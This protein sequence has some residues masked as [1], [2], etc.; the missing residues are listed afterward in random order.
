[1]EKPHVFLDY[2]GLIMDYQFTPETLQRAHDIALRLI[3]SHK[4]IHISPELL[5]ESHNLAIAEYRRAREKGNAEWSMDVIMGI[6]LENMGLEKKISS[7]TLGGIY[8]VYD[9]D[10][11]PMPTTLKSLPELRKVGEVGIISNLPHNAIGYELSTFGL[12]DVFFPIVVSYQVGY[13]KPHPVIYQEALGRAE[14]KPEQGVFFSHD[15]EEVD[16]ALAVGMQGYL[17]KN[18]AE[19][20]AKLKTSSK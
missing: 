5:R 11:K 10:T 18:L 7:R 3:N 16:G 8:M 4:G 20:L 9:H 1:M 13:R 14:I 15:Q 6:M 17:A 19:V 12:T 2:G